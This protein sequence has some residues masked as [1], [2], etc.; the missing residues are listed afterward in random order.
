MRGESQKVIPSL[1]ED[2]FS[3][4]VVKLGGPDYVS[5]EADGYNSSRVVT[6]VGRLAFLYKVKEV[7]TR[8]M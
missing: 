1:R 2:G 5:P 6:D 8:F 3:I 4:S 7:M